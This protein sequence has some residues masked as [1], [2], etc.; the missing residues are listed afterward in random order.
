MKHFL[1]GRRGFLISAMA[2][3]LS[4]TA[5]A[6]ERDAPVVLGSVSLSFYAVTGAIVAAVLQQLGHR[7]EMVSGLHEQIFPMLG[8][9]RIDLLAAAWLPEGHAAYWTRYGANAEEVTSLYE[10]ARFFWAVPDYI[11]ASQVSSIADL[12]RPEV[13]ARLTR[14]VQGIG[15]GAAISTV[16]RGAID[17]YELAAQ[18][19]SFRPGTQ[20]QWLESHRVAMAERRWF[21]FPTWTPQYLNRGG[22]LRPLNDP[23]GAFGGSNRAVLAGSR[24]RL[25][26]LP[27]RTRSVLSRLQI[28]IDAVEEMDGNVNLRQMTPDAAAQAWMATHGSHVDGWFSP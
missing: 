25:A 27:A 17:R 28:G 8:E 14:V 22:G 23:A 26:R 5:A 16:S 20:A 19:F 6:G 3:S 13:A 24:A 11:P 4:G 12:A 15:D 18:G 10:G 2:A 1:H 21:V 7:V 9:D